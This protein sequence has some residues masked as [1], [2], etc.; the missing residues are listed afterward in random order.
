MVTQ[1]YPLK[2]PEKG[3]PIAKFLPMFMEKGMAVTHASYTAQGALAKI[4]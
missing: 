3:K 4:G 2:P 1:K